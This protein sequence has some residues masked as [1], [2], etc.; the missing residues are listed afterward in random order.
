MQPAAP[1]HTMFCDVEQNRG[2]GE[3][4]GQPVRG[5][6]HHRHGDDAEGNSEDQRPGRRHVMASERTMTGAPHQG[7]DIA[8]DETVQRIGTTRCQRAAD[9][10]G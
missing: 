4:T 5:Q 3:P 7:V 8:V 10:G 1:P 2:S 6:P 9:H